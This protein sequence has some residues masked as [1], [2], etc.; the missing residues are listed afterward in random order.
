[1]ARAIKEKYRDEEILLHE[2]T[3]EYRIPDSP[4]SM[5][6]RVDE[7]ARRDGEPIVKDCKSTKQRTKTELK[8][9]GEEYT[10]GVQ[11]PFY[12]VGSRTFGGG[13][14]TNTFIYYLVEQR[15]SGV[16]IYEF[17]TSRTNLELKEFARS[18]HQTAETILFY[19]REFGLEKPWPILPEVFNSG[20]APLYGHK[21]YE[22]YVP[23]GYQSKREHL[24]IA[25][26]F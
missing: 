4:H 12:L 10:K 24:S 7:I 20:Y 18:V 16:E 19:K 5:V 8:R 3:F 1:M 22:D 25:E 21:L 6:G 23:E 15:K 14:A 26:I 11:V 17:P 13:L 2:K 9:K